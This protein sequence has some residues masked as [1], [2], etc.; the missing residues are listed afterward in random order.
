VVVS[1]SATVRVEL[2]P[3]FGH[4]GALSSQTGYGRPRP[5]FV[6]RIP[7]CQALNRG[8]WVFMWRRLSQLGM[9][10]VVI[11][12][13]LASTNPAQQDQRA[14]LR[15]RCAPKSRGAQ[16]EAEARALG[17]PTPAKA[18]AWLRTLTEEPHVAGTDADRKTAEFVRDKLR[19]WGWKVEIAEYEV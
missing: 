2:G 16:A 7:L 4:Q 8:G 3:G 14:H 18:R 11:L 1:S 6:S 12:L 5:E 19:E 9:H 13:M 15:G 10:S 17:V